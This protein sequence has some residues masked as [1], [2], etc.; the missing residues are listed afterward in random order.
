[1]MYTTVHYHVLLRKEMPAFPEAIKCCAYQRE[2][3]FVT[4]VAR[5]KKGLCADLFAPMLL[6]LLLP[7]GDSF[8]DTWRWFMQFV[9]SSPRREV[10]SGIKSSVVFDDHGRKVGAFHFLNGFHEVDRTM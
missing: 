7:D 1:M 9:L 6:M 8:Q 4:P 10:T 5:S 3:A 2:C